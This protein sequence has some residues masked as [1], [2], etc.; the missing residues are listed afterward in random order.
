MLGRAVVVKRKLK[1]VT[2]PWLP[3]LVARDLD[4]SVERKVVIET[5]ED[6]GATGVLSKLPSQDF[7]GNRSIGQDSDPTQWLNT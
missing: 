2:I 7:S 4:R 1:A 5:N 3:V 6:M